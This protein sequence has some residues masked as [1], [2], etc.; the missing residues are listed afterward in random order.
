MRRE[1]RAV[2]SASSRPDVHTCALPR[3]CA[4]V[5]AVPALQ[6]L[7]L[8]HKLRTLRIEE[9]VKEAEQEVRAVTVPLPLGFRH[10]D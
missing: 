10:R 1:T 7:F 6:A 8:Q 3:P 4:A 5:V 2:L 9:Q